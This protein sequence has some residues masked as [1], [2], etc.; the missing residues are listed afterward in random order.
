MQFMV[1]IGCF[2]LPATFAPGENKPAD[3]PESVL[4]VIAKA[5]KDNRSVE[6]ERKGDAAITRVGYSGNELRPGSIPL[7]AFNAARP[8]P[9]PLPWR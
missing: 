9:C 5:F 3:V 2:L 6:Q 1:L 4:K 7:S 8:W